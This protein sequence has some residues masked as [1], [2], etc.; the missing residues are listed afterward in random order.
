MEQIKDRRNDMI[1]FLQCH[2][3]K[4]FV[5]SCRQVQI[6]LEECGDKVW[7]EFREHLTIVLNKAN[8][9]QVHGKKAEIK[10]F[11][12]S[13]LHAEVLLDRLEWY[14]ELLDEGLYLDE[15]EVSEYY[16][17]AVLQKVY[18]RDLEYFRNL[19][20]KH[21]IR[22]QNYEWIEIKKYYSLRYKA[23]MREMVRSISNL[24]MD[25]MLNSK[26]ILSDRPQIIYGDYMEKFSILYT[27]K[28]QNQSDGH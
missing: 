4:Q 7:E 2:M 9:R 21:F 11:A 14:F 19:L 1:Q 26:I 18:L 24:I 13:F 22:I 5:L 3:E 16:C 25:E 10:Y 23:L 28:E 27:G 15:E 12:V 8:L 20:E 17:P 6:Q